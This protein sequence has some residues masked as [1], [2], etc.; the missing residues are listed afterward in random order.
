MK[1]SKVAL[2]ICLLLAIS[3]PFVLEDLL[4]KT[5]GRFAYVLPFALFLIAVFL[6]GFS[7]DKKPYTPKNWAR[8][9]ALTCIF[10]LL[11]MFGATQIYISSQPIAG[12]LFRVLFLLTLLA[13]ILGAGNLGYLMRLK[14]E[15][16][17]PG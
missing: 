17:R 2:G 16:G 7:G 14:T 3:F 4:V 6:V 1:L 8:A 11:C 13:A 10:I 5:I 9:V 12:G 15:R